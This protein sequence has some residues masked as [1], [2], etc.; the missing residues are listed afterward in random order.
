MLNRSDKLPDA[1]N[2]QNSC[3]YERRIEN[4]SKLY[5]RLGPLASWLSNHKE[6]G[7]DP[8]NLG[9]AQL[10]SD[11][12]LDVDAQYIALESNNKIHCLKIPAQLNSPNGLLDQEKRTYRKNKA[13]KKSKHYQEQTHLLGLFDNLNGPA[14]C[15]NHQRSPRL[16]KGDLDVGT[17]QTTN[18]IVLE[19][20]HTIKST[21]CS[22]HHNTKL[23]ILGC[24]TQVRT[25]PQVIPEIPVTLKLPVAQWI[26]TT[27]RGNLGTNHTV[28]TVS[29][30]LRQNWSL[31]HWKSMM[32]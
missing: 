29:L 23:L 24:L 18:Q 16:T 2:K 30:S 28:S 20:D 22:H 10:L 4:N 13:L 26:S 11:G 19:N 15:A 6:K 8:R 32:G 31:F 5:E 9:T 1:Q 14:K 25:R 27:H 17:G 7:V 12:N 3:R 21:R